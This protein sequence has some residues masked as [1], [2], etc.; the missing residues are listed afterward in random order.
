MVGISYWATVRV[1]T[2]DVSLIIMLYNIR[3]LLFAMVEPNERESWHFGVKIT[4]MSLFF[5]FSQNSKYLLLIRNDELLECF[6]L[7]G[8]SACKTFKI[9]RNWIPSGWCICWHLKED[10]ALAV[11]SRNA[12][13]KLDQSGFT[14]LQQKQESSWQPSSYMIVN[15]EM[16]VFELWRI[17]ILSGL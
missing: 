17:G 11:T 5:S 9:Q 16:F 3:Y 2:G 15:T 12:G 14:F 13:S 4:I 10:H 1:R 7:F 8:P 6:L